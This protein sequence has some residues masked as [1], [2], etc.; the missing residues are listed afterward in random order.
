MLGARLASWVEAGSPS[1]YCEI[2]DV[3]GSAPREAGAAM[4][5]R[6]NAVFGT[7]G[8]GALEDLATGC[9]IWRAAKITGVCNAMRQSNRSRMRRHFLR[10]QPASTFWTVIY[11]GCQRKLRIGQRPKASQV[12][13]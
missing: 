4:I 9:G 11:G 13:R 6:A 2:T 8:G 10:T 1:I 7:I 5:V 12:G 3:Q